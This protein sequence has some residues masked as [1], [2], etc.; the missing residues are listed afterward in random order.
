MFDNTYKLTY[1]PH[2]KTLSSDVQSNN[3][4]S[5]AD[6]DAMIE[7]SKI[8]DQAECERLLA[9]DDALKNATDEVLV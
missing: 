6:N 8:G 5:Q 9:K 3:L 7:A 4:A 2:T 1:M